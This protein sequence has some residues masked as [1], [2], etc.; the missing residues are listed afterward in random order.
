MLR[1][2]V[3]ASLS[4]AALLP[5][6]PGFAQ[7]GAG[8]SA[9]L[10]TP[11]ETALGVIPVN[12]QY[13]PYCVNRYGNNATPGSSDMWSA[14]TI[15]DKVA[16]HDG[17]AVMFCAGEIYGVNVTQA[18]D[19]A[20]TALQMTTHWVCAGPAATVR[21]IDYR[22]SVAAYTV[23]CRSQHNLYLT[24]LVFD[25]QVTAL[26]A[27]ANPGRL[28]N[29][30]LGAVGAFA[31]EGRESL[32]SKVYGVN[33]AYTHY[34]TI[35]N[36]RFENFLR[37]GLRIDCRA[38]PAVASGPPWSA[39][40]SLGNRVL[41]CQFRRNRGVYGD[42][43]YAE[44]YEDLVI[45]D[46]SAYDYQRIGFVF[47]NAS[48]LSYS[49]ANGTLISNCVADYGHDAVISASQSNAGFWLETGDH[50]A[51]ANCVSKNTMIGF[52]SGFAGGAATGAYRPWS[53]SHAFTACAAIRCRQQGFRLAYGNNDINVVLQNCSIE[54]NRAAAPYANCVGGAPAGVEIDFTPPK[55]AS[56][57]G[58]AARFGL[59]GCR[60]DMVGFGAAGLSQYS[61]INVLNSQGSVD[62]ENA[63][64]QQV[65]IR[66]CSFRWIAAG[67]ERTNDAAVQ[68]AHESL[69]SPN[70]GYVGDIIFSG[71]NN[72]GR[73]YSGAALISNCVNHSFGY[74]LFM[75]EF[76]SPGSVLTV[77]DSNISMRTGG[78]SSNAAG[79]LILTDC[80]VDMRGQLG[81]GQVC[82]TSCTFCDWNAAQRD[83]TA[84]QAGEFRLAN[85]RFERQLRISMNGSASQTTHPLRLLASG[86]EW[87]M[88]FSVEPGLRLEIAAGT[89]AAANMSGCTFRHRG[90]QAA[91]ASAM[92]MCDTT[93]GVVQFAGAGNTFDA[94]FVNALGGH[95]I[96]Y[97]SSG[98]R[99]NDAPQIAAPPFLTVF[100]AAQI[101]GTGT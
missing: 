90:K 41:N 2:D 61:G 42:G 34:C 12:S 94:G 58:V 31:D 72:G 73:R 86:T 97:S 22:A 50:Y 44:E 80:R 69:K 67:G 101:L 26:S 70:Y 60:F 59:H 28:P 40:I 89:Y 9:Y 52:G 66:D 98:P 93:S 83:R 38:V 29:I 85:C 65:D 95:C 87:H 11:G 17:A 47:Q 21:R 62:P 43:L 91:A 3:L 78:A 10:R 27:S 48:G 92:I 82:A 68:Q 25:G 63:Y 23:E 51:I 54:I 35:E 13:P 37:A 5:N 84:W 16:S 32:W 88:D 20:H 71:L 1:R 77:R 81:W 24:G 96:Q 14:I 74:L 46:C 99:Y 64:Q 8:A 55:S 6:R 19:H 39:T 76:G 45:A 36:C 75:S 33:F 49:G 53:G 18:T 30:D 56:G 4:G 100:G 57:A 79:T 7:A 15:A